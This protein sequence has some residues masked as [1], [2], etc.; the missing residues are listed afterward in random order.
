MSEHLTPAAVP[1]AT[2]IETSCRTVGGYLAAW[3]ADATAEDLAR[4]AVDH[5]NAVAILTAGG[6]DLDVRRL[7]PGDPGVPDDAA[8]VIIVEDRAAPVDA[9]T[10]GDG[11]AGAVAHHAAAIERDGYSILTLPGP[12]HRAAAGV[13]DYMRA[14]AVALDAIALVIQHLRDRHGDALRVDRLTAGR[15]GADPQ[16]IERAW[17]VSLGAREAGNDA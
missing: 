12:R 2:V 11:I 16:V 14:R 5:H 13:G 6:M 15:M 7:G 17:V 4:G 1:L 8:M 9:P 10:T 3:P